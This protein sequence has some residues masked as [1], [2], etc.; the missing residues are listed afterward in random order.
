MMGWPPEDAQV[1]DAEAHRAEAGEAKAPEETPPASPT[2]KAK[3]R[4]EVEG[5]EVTGSSPGAP[6]PCNRVADGLKAPSIRL[7]SFQK[8]HMRSFH[9]AWISFLVVSPQRGCPFC[10]FFHP[11][12]GAFVLTPQPNLKLTPRTRT[13]THTELHGMVRSGE[14]NGR[15]R[16][17]AAPDQG[18]DPRGQLRIGAWRRRTRTQ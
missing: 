2:V 10:F 3:Q 11:P 1:D 17:L 4:L 12:R 7:W 18:P 13:R 6:S 9:L 14:P 15:D 5:P 8:P 16:L